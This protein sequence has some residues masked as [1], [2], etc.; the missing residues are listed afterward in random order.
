MSARIEEL[1]ALINDLQEKIADPSK[2]GCDPQALQRRLEVALR[3]LATLNEARTD[4]SQLL[5]G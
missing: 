5:K 3:E 4:K 1:T 2:C